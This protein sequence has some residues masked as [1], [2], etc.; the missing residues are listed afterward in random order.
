MPDDTPRPRSTYRVQVRPG[1]DL[2]TTAELSDYLA[3]LGVTHLYSAPLLTAT[4]GS[5]HGY[6]VVDHR[7][8]NPEVGGEAGRQRL[9]RA[10]R[11]AG[12]GLV[13]DIVPTTRVGPAAANPALWDVCAGTL[14]GDPL[15]RIDWDG[16]G[17]C[18]GAAN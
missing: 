15:V 16:V 13:V 12:L 1:F 6:D 2:D 10:L 3:D 4:P 11:A 9:L 18:C 5:A 14:L 7:A 17:C 8:V